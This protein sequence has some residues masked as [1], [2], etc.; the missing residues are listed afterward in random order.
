MLVT[1]RCHACDGACRVIKP[2]P[3]SK[4]CTACRSVGMT[5][6]ACPTCKGAGRVAKPATVSPGTADGNDRFG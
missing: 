2:D 5:T 3:D 1:E 4:P 6:E